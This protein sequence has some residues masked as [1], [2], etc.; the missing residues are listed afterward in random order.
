VA[1]EVGAD[2]A[3]AEDDRGFLGTIERV[4]IAREAIVGLRPGATISRVS[5]SGSCDQISSVTCGIT[6]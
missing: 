5:R 2:A 6:G 3:P 4:E 1:F